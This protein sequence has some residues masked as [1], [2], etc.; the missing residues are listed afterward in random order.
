MALKKIIEG[1]EY[2]PLNTNPR[3]DNHEYVD[4][5]LPSK[6]LWA[7]FNIGS[8]GIQK[9]GNKFIWGDSTIYTKSINWVDY[10]FVTKYQSNGP[11]RM[12][13]P[14]GRGYTLEEKRNNEEIHKI[15][16]EDY[17]REH[18]VKYTLIG[19]DDVYN[20][21]CWGMPNRINPD[22][23][24][25]LDLIDDTA[26]ILWGGRWKMPTKGDYEELIRELEWDWVTI[27]DVR[28]LKGESKNGRCIYFPMPFTTDEYWSSSL[29][30]T[31]EQ[32]AYALRANSS[33]IS[34]TK[35]LRIFNK[36]IRP[37]L[38]KY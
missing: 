3:I 12:P 30:N 13:I 27:N 5:G 32:Y 18:L 38:K 17:A 22:N 4:L 19:K 29:C 20:K 15:M 26:H 6:T 25:V 9:S 2:N 8:N 34:L 37:V 7:C 24:M 33:S 36:Y 35:C 1:E 21:N 31:E 23:K 28:C 10:K 11:V 16:K 14:I